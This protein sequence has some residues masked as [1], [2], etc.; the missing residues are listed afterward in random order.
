MPEDLVQ[1]QILR[2]AGE[3][4]NSHLLRV[5][6]LLRHFLEHGHASGNVEATDGN[7]QVRLQELL[8][9]I[10]RARELVG[11]NPTRP[12]RALPPDSR[13]MRMIFAGFTRV[14]VSS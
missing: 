1:T 7:L 10:D 8:G 6:H 9:Q 3:E 5:D 11:L 14:L 2:F 12:I 4:G 13:I